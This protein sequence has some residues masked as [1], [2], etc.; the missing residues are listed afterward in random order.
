MLSCR[1]KRHSN[2]DMSI[3]KMLLIVEWHFID[4][5]I[6]FCYVGTVVLVRGA[7]CGSQDAEVE[8]ALVEID[9][10]TNKSS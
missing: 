8:D 5:E 4:K 10:S 1:G 9:I 3:I 6:G 7:T 2:N